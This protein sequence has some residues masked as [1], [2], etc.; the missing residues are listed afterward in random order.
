MVAGGTGIA[1]LISLMH[2][3]KK[4]NITLFYGCKNKSEFVPK[5]FLLQNKKIIYVTEDDS[6]GHKGFVTDVFK[7][8]VKNGKVNGE[9][10]ILYVCGPLPMIKTAVKLARKFNFKGG[11]LMGVRS[12]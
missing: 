3:Y 4:E 2:I 1:S 10:S 12:Y 9:N 7:R 8:Y 6:L 5:R 11:T